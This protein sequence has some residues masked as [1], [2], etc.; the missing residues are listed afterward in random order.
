M[1]SCTKTSF[2][3]RFLTADA[4]SLRGS[5]GYS[6]DMELILQNVLPFASWTDPVTRKLP[7]T[8]PAGPDDWIIMDD[9]F[10]AQ[11][12]L[13]DHIIAEQEEAATACLPEG[14]AAAM[15]LFDAVLERISR[16]P[17]YVI[18]DRAVGRPDGASVPLDRT[19]P[20]A[21][22]GRLVQP[23]LC[24]LDK[25]EGAAEH[26]LVA[27]VVCF[28][29]GW[30][31]DQKIGR[32]LAR[33]HLPTEPYDDGIAKRV[34]R[35][36]DNLRTG[37]PIWRAN[38][39]LM[40]DPRLNQ[41]MREFEMPITQHDAPGYVR[42]ERQVLFRLP[43]TGAIVFSIHTIVVALESLTDAQRNALEIHEPDHY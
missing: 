27:G 15:E 20:M 3:C 31:L 22:I 40:A 21:T 34:Q 7:G 24:V 2:P 43:K 14:R 23:D 35:M 18:G 4:L 6:W 16:L 37:H 29:S 39:H 28:P 10:E 25:A 36:F 13:R 9:A 12:A 1:P 38:G 19:R 17:G 42:S 5:G 11:M 30:S 33:I 8:R 26:R 41:R 32:G